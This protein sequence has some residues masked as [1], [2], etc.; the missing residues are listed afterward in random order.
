DRSVSAG[1]DIVGSQVTTGD[2]NYNKMK[3]V[4]VAI[5]DAASVDLKKALDEFTE[6]LAA[7]QTDDRRKLDNA[8][9]DAAA[10]AEK[11]AP[12]EKELA[13]SL[14]R[15]GRYAKAADNFSEHAENIA[16]RAAPLIAVLKTF[17]VGLAA[18]LGISV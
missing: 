10:E 9:D 5:P 1:R 3:D 13:D 6:A 2:G 18:T 7:L 12:D 15:V 17:G 11:D 14:E 8:L 4:S 16:E